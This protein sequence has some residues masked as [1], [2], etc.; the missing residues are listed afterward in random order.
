MLLVVGA[1]LYE[2]DLLTGLRRQ[3]AVPVEV[4]RQ[5]GRYQVDRRAL[6]PEPVRDRVSGFFGGQ[7]A[8]EVGQQAADT[9]PARDRYG[10]QP[11]DLALG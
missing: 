1:D 2:Q 6:Q 3:V 4:V 7:R 10:Q 5:R 11:C 9:V 8:E